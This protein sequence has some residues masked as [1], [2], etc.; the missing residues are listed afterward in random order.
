MFSVEKYREVR[1]K[2][3]V[4]G[5]FFQGDESSCAYNALKIITV[6]FDVVL[7]PYILRVTEVPIFEVLREIP[8]GLRKQF[9]SVLTA[10][11]NAHILVSVNYDELSYLEKVKKIA[12]HGP[13]IR[14]LVLHLTDYCNLRCRYCFI[15]GNIPE[16]YKRQ[17]MTSKYAGLWK[18]E[19]VFSLCQPS[20]EKTFFPYLR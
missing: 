1:L 3:S 16:N 11:C 19:A 20:R 5:H 14:V 10:I 7:Y 13:M 2:K 12:F 4:F 6:Y 8:K 17:N 9:V 18:N 15:E